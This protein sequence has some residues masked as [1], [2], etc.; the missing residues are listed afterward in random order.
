MHSAR[1]CVTAKPSILLLLFCKERDYTRWGSCV[2]VCLSNLEDS[3][4]SEGLTKAKKHGKW[5]ETFYNTTIAVDLAL[6]DR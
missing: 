5:G 1:L 6:Q 4:C 3:S 2:F